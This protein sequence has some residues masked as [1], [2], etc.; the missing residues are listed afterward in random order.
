[1]LQQ[2]NKKLPK[3]YVTW[4]LLDCRCVS[5]SCSRFSKQQ[6]ELTWQQMIEEAEPKT[7]R[8]FL[9]REFRYC[10]NKHCFRTTSTRFL[11]TSPFSFFNIQPTG[12]TWY[13]VLEY[14]RDK[15]VL[16]AYLLS[17]KKSESMFVEITSKPRHIRS[18]SQWLVS[19]TRGTGEGCSDPAL[20]IWKPYWQLFLLRDT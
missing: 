15:G 17:E 18:Y 1:M 2:Q 4:R 9:T 7:L 13:L 19:M 8:G 14:I 5:V 10:T 3:V 12:N 11:S 16:L 6:T 20:F